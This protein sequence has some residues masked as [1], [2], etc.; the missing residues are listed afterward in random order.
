MRKSEG[1][2]ASSHSYFHHSFGVISHS[3][4]KLLG[5]NQGQHNSHIPLALQHIQL[6]FKVFARFSKI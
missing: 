1:P 3:K 2:R 6:H 4:V 5:A